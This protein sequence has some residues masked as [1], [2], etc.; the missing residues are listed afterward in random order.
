MKRLQSERGSVAIEFALI[1][2]ILA[3]LLLG[4]MEFGRAYNA[5]ITITAAARE[6]A[7]TMAI[8]NNPG[9]AK[10]S[11]QTASTS[12]VPQLTNEQITVSP[13]ACTAGAD[14]AITVT[15]RLT[16]MTGFFGEGIDLTGKAVMRC[17]G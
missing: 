1:L 10:T 5:Q 3:T 12:L 6:G 2:P 7:R 13:A 11:V 4:I 9:A 15:Y 16:S 8:K 14:T 17:G